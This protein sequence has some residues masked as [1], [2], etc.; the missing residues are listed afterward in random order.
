[1]DV[2][3]QCGHELG[4]G[5]FCI[6]CGQPVTS[7]GP[8]PAAVHTVHDGDATD[9]AERPRVVAAPPAT[10]GTPV[11]ARFPLYA[12]EGPAPATPPEPDDPPAGETTA[13]AAVPVIDQAGRHRHVDEDA[14][15]GAAAT[16]VPWVA[17]L[18]LLLLVA[19]GGLWLLLGGD[20]QQPVRRATEPVRTE[21]P[22]RDHRTPEGRAT[23]SPAPEVPAGDLAASVTVRAPRPAPATE[24]VTGNPVTFAAAHML[25]GN[26]ETCW[27]MAG[28]GTG[29][30]ITFSF[31]EPTEVVE[32]GVVNGYAKTAVDDSGSYDWYA[33][34]RR[35]L[36][37][38]WTF[39]DGTV[40]T[41]D[42][43][44]TRSM[45]TVRLGEGVETEQ[46]TMRL[47]EVTPPGT[48][49]ASRDYTAISEVRLIGAAAG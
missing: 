49:P 13:V 15:S 31:E 2:C 12:D 44:E 47:I 30:A 3:S 37:V 46:V 1:M 32:V 35:T 7:G 4:I 21:K 43:R 9:T 27:R 11:P 16:W 29:E 17:G 40:R 25:D 41:Q 14:R 39:D 38:E 42:L 6:N 20:D 5:R 18:T 48:G 45:Q 19:A 8:A 26:P 23:V 28:D 10:G 33:G 34:N 22:S 36:R 24:D